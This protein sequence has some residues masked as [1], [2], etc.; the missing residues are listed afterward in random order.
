MKLAFLS[1]SHHDAKVADWLQRNLEHYKLP[2]NVFHPIDPENR[3]LRPI[4]RDRTDLSGGVLS[5]IIDKNLEESKYLIIICSRR[6]ARSEWVSKEAQY[7]I[8]HGR[9]KQIIP[10]VVDGIPYSGGRRECMPI[11]MREYVNEHP[12]QELLCID[13]VAEGENRAFMQVVS[14]LVDVPFDVMY[15]RHRRRRNHL[16]GLQVTIAAIVF[17][18]IAFF[19]TPVNTKVQ[20]CDVI[21]RLPH[22]EGVLTVEGSQYPI[23]STQY[24]TIVE[25][26]SFPGYM[27]GRVLDVTFEAPYYDTVHAQLDLG[28]GLTSSVKLEL[29]RDNKFSV[30]AG[31][32]LSEDGAPIR[33]AYVRLGSFQAVTDATGYFCVSLPVEIQSTEQPILIQKD[34]FEEI[35][36]ADECPYEDLLYVMHPI[37]QEEE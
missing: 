11:Y 24:D 21:N 35:I 6:A 3:Y 14:R 29:V 4:F 23:V 17:C 22:E 7:F 12:D 37:S 34:G 26:A 13:M 25:L 15:G 33:G 5:E 1:Y 19:I 18:L 36:R 28:Y 27:R 16:V 10:L 2:K 8:E 30:F 31:H 9:M 32:V 20:L